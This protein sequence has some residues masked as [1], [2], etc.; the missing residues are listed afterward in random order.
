MNEREEYLLY[1]Y[2]VCEM[3]VQST[4]DLLKV[5]NKTE[6]KINTLVM[7]EKREYEH[8]FQKVKERLEENDISPQSS[9]L[10]AKVSSSM[11]IHMELA[12]DN[13]DTKIADMLIQG[14]TMGVLEI[15]KKLKKY[16]ATIT[17]EE[18]ALGEAIKDFQNKNIKK[19][20]KYL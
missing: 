8:Y 15:T 1:L 6:N 5:L 16:D 13:S 14:Y 4:G 10:I 20:K 11:G 9:G 17:K 2:Q 12:K 7:E 18:K 3:G 19:L